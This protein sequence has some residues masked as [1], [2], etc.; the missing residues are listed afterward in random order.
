[1]SRWG[2]DPPDED[3]YDIRYDGT[4]CAD[5]GR[6]AVAWLCETCGDAR[7]YWAVAAA[8]RLSQTAQTRPAVVDVALVPVSHLAGPVVDVA[9]VPVSHL[10]ADA[11]FLKRMAKAILRADLTHV[12]EVA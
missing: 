9:L 12:R 3:A 7:E 11:R 6:P 1:M 4:A 8:M 2:I 5:C 10:D